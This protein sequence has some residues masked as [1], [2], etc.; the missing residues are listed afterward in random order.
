MNDCH[1]RAFL[2]TSIAAFAGLAASLPHIGCAARRANAHLGRMRDDTPINWDAFLELV[3]A[4]AARQTEKSW[5]ESD[6]VAR[7]AVIARRLNLDDPVI[8]AAF[9][10]LSNRNPAFPEIAVPHKERLFQISLIQFEQGEVIHHHDHPGMTGVLLCS[11]GNLRVTN[12]SV[13]GPAD[14]GHLVL[15]QDGDESMV[16]GQVSTLTSTDRNIHRVSAPVFSE[17]VD[18]FTP[19]YDADRIAR[20]RWFEVDD[21]PM[22]GRAGRYLAKVKG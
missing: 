3:H 8:R 12:Y 9:A 4:E 5:N 14:G 1:R 10:R 19:P 20:S 16:R 2:K 6:Y 13:E 18:I 17:V 15:R 22:D 21:E 7:A 11:T